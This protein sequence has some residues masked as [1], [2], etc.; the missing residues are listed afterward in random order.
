MA[1]TRRTSD[2]P[3]VSVIGTT[4]D[5]WIS[6]DIYPPSR[7]VARLV[8]VRLP[9]TRLITAWSLAHFGYRAAVIAL[10]F[11]ALSATG[12]AWMV[13]LVAGA[14]GLPTITAPWWT[15]PLQPR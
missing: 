1:T 4:Y 5:Q 9:L 3:A 2:I 10:P 13:G 11:L 12:S 6:F 8:V 7:P 14:A 15:G